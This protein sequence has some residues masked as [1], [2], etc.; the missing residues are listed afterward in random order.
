[1]KK[2][3]LLAISLFICFHD[4]VEFNN[5]AG[6]NINPAPSGYTF[7]NHFDDTFEVIVTDMEIIRPVA[8]TINATSAIVKKEVY[9]HI[10][11]PPIIN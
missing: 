7:H 10:W 6:S 4:V 8:I 11:K 9:N 1:M 5:V 3:L 2:Y